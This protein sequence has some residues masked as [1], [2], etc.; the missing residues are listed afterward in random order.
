MPA[1][2]LRDFTTPT[3]LGMLRDVDC[4]EQFLGEQRQPG[5]R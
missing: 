1:A 3:E 5:W 2:F 4:L